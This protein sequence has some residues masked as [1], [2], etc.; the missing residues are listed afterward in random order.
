MRSAPLPKAGHRLTDK[1]FETCLNSPATS[2][3][4]PL[5]FPEI[6]ASESLGDFPSVEQQAHKQGVALPH[7]HHPEK[8]DAREV[9]KR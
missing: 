6:Q 8:T 4:A 1:D 9:P 2:V 5:S 7:R 3:L